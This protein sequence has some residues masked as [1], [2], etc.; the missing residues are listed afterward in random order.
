[1]MFEIVSAVISI[2][3]SLCVGYYLVEPFIANPNSEN[4]LTR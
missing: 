1:M 3:L 2:L 4:T